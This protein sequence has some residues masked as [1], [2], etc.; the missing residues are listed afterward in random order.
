MARIT[1][2]TGA[3]DIRVLSFSA[4]STNG[5]DTRPATNSTAAYLP[6]P[7]KISSRDAKSDF[8]LFLSM[9]SLPI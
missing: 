1:A 7:R 3:K 6:R 9:N 5:T 4:G 2:A 8:R